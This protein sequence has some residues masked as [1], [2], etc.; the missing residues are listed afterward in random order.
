MPPATPRPPAFTHTSMRLRGLPSIAAAPSTKRRLGDEALNTLP[1]NR[2]RWAAATLQATHSQPQ[3]EPGSRQWWLPCCW[4][5]GGGGRTDGTGDPPPC[6]P[7][8]RCWLDTRGWTLRRAHRLRAQRVGRCGAGRPGT[9]PLGALH[10]TQA[11]DG[12]PG[13][14]HHAAPPPAPHQQPSR[15]LST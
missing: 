3:G 12:G 4:G 8:V 14:C 9:F 13:T 6:L 7:G 5:R 15:W 11:R 10:A 1:S 2:R